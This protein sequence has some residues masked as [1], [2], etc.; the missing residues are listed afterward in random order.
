[1]YKAT[2]GIITTRDP[3]LQLFGNADGE[4]FFGNRIRFEVAPTALNLG[5]FED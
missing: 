2:S 5:F 1:M 3:S 4:D